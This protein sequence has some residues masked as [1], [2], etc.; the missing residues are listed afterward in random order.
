MTF[1]PITLA[2][3]I[4]AFAYLQWRL[5]TMSSTFDTDLAALTSAVLNLTTEVTAATGE[6]AALTASLAAS[7][8]APT[9]AELATLTSATSAIQAA[10]TALGAAVPPPVVPA[11]IANPGT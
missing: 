5:R 10:A 3:V 7:G 4:L 9:A 1:D 2:T 6:I 8:Q 11:P